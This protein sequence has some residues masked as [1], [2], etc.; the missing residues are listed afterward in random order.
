MS[1][2]TSVSLSPPRKRNVYLTALKELSPFF[3][4]SLNLSPLLSVPLFRP[5]LSFDLACYMPLMPWENPRVSFLCTCG[6][7]Q[8]R[9]N[10]GKGWCLVLGFRYP[11]VLVHLLLLYSFIPPVSFYPTEDSLIRR[12]G[13]TI[14]SSLSF[15]L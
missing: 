8:K 12:Y 2:M 3:L 5:S 11:A 13:S 4:F 9:N 14:P 1:T 7:D 10:E 6:S 15:S